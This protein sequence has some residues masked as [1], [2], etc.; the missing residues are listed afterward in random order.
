MQIAAAQSADA[1]AALLPRLLD[2]VRALR[3]ELAE[4][5]LDRQAE[6]IRLLQREMDSARNLRTTLEAQ[7]R[8][9]DEELSRFR[10][11]L[12]TAEFNSAERA[13]I[14]SSKSEAAA[15][16]AERI[17]RERIAAEQAESAVSQDLAREK[18]QHRKLGE[19][20]A[21]LRQTR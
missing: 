20:L 17:R 8:S 1:A 3:V 21:A 13:L 14:E 16:A 4:S 5:R 19:G 9:Q 7:A 10:N 2:E 6:K 11:Q 15:Q 18:E 12:Q